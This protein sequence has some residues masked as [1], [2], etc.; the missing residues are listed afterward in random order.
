MPYLRPI[1]HCFA[2]FSCALLASSVGCGLD[3]TVDIDDSD[4]DPGQATFALESTSSLSHS[5]EDLTFADSNGTV[6]TVTESRLVV[7][8]IEM[9]LP[10]FIDCTDIEAQLAPEV[11]CDSAFDDETDFSDDDISNSAELKIEGPFVLDLVSGELNPPLGEIRIP[12][13]T[14]QEVDVEFEKATSTTRGVSSGDEIIGNSWIVRAEF[15]DEKGGERNLVMRVGFSGEIDVEPDR[16]INVPEGSR[17]TFTFDVA[18]W[19]ENI[20]LTSCLRD[21]DLKTSGQQVL[22]TNSTDSGECLNMKARLENT[23]KVSGGVRIE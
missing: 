13:V 1:S 7:Q 17:V 9:E 4:F 5:S 23:L 22:V 2:A 3:D 14:Y 11:K 15:Q 10:N 12:A 6:Y 16:G 8:E 19:L 20:P 21:G 18:R